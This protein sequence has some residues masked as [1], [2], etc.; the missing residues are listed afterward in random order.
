MLTPDALTLRRFRSGIA[1]GVPPLTPHRAL[2]GIALLRCRIRPGG[3]RGVL[4]H[5]ARDCSRWDAGS[6]ATVL[7]VRSRT[8]HGIAPGVPSLLR[9]TALEEVQPPMCRGFR[10]A[11]VPDLAQP[12]P[13]VGET[14]A[15]A[16][17]LAPL[18]WALGQG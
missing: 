17:L 8:W 10:P 7:M 5:R 12:S 1:P 11:S 14:R 16:G 3:A 13:A 9:A 2:D 6:G 18:A 15:R 4:L